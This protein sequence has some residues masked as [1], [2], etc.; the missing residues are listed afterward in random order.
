MHADFET[1][2][3]NNFLNDYATNSPCF[4]VPFNMVTALERLSHR[5]ATILSASHVVNVSV[6]ETTCRLAN[7]ALR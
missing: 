4:G 2:V 6:V 1:N 3:G 7:R 5:A